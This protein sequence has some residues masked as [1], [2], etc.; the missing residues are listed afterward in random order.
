MSTHAVQDELDVLAVAQDERGSCAHCRVGTN[1]SLLFGNFS[2]RGLALHLLL[3]M[4]GRYESGDFHVWLYHLGVGGG[5]TCQRTMVDSSGV[6]RC[7]AANVSTYV[8]R[9]F[10]LGLTCRRTACRDCLARFC[11]IRNLFVKALGLVFWGGT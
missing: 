4:F 8:D 5:R 1:C 10:D 2:E 9:N 7:Q 11:C 6:F 3:A